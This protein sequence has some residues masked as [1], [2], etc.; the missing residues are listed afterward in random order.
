[1]IELATRQLFSARYN[2]RIRLLSKT[3]LATTPYF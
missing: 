3:F 1:M 2:C